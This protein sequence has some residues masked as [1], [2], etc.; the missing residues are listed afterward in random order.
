MDTWKKTY[1]KNPQI[2][3]RRIADEFIL[4]PIKQK[5]GDLQNIYTFNELGSRAWDLIDGQRTEKDIQSLIA[6]E[7]EVS[8]ED[9][10]RDL[11]GFLGELESL[12]LIKLV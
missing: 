8:S 7:F 6:D 1:K 12:E 3:S 9:L 4:V 11:R 10:Q 5:V 2:V